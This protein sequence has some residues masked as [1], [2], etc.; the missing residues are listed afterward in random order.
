MIPARW[1]PVFGPRQ[2]IDFAESRQADAWLHHVALGDPSFDSFRRRPGNP[3]IRGRPPFEW[4]VNGFLFEDPKSGNWYSYVGHYPS[5]YD[6]GR[7][8]KPVP[9]CRVYRSKDRGKSWDEI[10]PIFND[11]VFRFEG[12]IHAAQPCARRVGRFRRR[13][14]PHG[15][16]L[17]D[18]KHHLGECFHPSGGADSGVGYAWA[19]RPEGPFHRAAPDPSHQP[20]AETIRLEP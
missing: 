2:T 17:G 4:P 11:P 3:I 5:N 19:E 1:T 20:D 13:A 12:D 18:R 15:L 6:I 8:D 10:G 14:L 7:P 9:H 16:R